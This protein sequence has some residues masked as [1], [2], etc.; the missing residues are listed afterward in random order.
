MQTATVDPLVGRTLEGRYRIL[1]RIARGGMSTVYSAVDER[2]DRLVA[3]KVMSSALSADP[4]FSDR[5][6]REARAAARLTHLNTVAVYDQGY[7]TADGGDHVFLVMELVQGRTLRDLIRERGGKFTTAEALSILQP[8]LSALSAAHSA[9]IVHRDVKPENILLSDDGVVKVADFGLARAVEADASSTRTGLM[10]GTVAYCSPEQITRGHA[11]P[12]SDVYACGIMLFELLTGK[13]PYRGESA[14]NVAY[15]HVHSRVPAP[16]SKVRGIPSDIDELVVLATDPDPA[17]RPADAGEFLAE[18]SDVREALNLPVTPV[19]ARPRPSTRRGH[20]DP[21]RPEADSAT[22]NLIAN[23]HAGQHDTQLVRGHNTTPTRGGPIRRP[24]GP[25]PPVVI[26]PPKRRKQLTDRQR[27]RRR[28]LIALLVVILLGV[29][30]GVAAWWFASGRYSKVPDVRGYAQTAAEK[31]LKDADLHVGS[32]TRA[33]SETVPVNEVIGTQPGVGSRV[34][35]HR[36][37]SITVSLGKHRITVPTTRNLSL[38]DAEKAVGDRGL[39]Y[40]VSQAADDKIASGKVIS[41]SPAAGSKVKPDQLVMIVVSTGPPILAIPNIDQ[42]TPV[43]DANTT[44]KQAGFKPTDTEQFNDTVAKGTVIS[45]SPT[46]QAV[47]FSPITVTVS[48]GPQLV[49]I[50]PIA[51][52]S[53][54]AEAKAQLEAL[55]LVVTIQEFLPLAGTDHVYGVDPAPGQSVKVGST[56]TLIVY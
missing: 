3:V 7:D 42:G 32:V 33:F 17:E 16:S 9:G 24:D 53:P 39:H 26:P 12:R 20:P 55:N 50:P 31:S 38:D 36:T 18:I 21:R 15:Q 49:T 43:A 5:F 11:D 46:G 22:T 23:G 52:G 51:Q 27:H 2:L 10:M 56:V 8:V 4:A 48:K 1:D 29:G 47:K 35:R 6:T 28:G 40:R 14:M 37:V 19:P 45:I 25:P 54:T 41:S 13:P 34:E 30:A 44:L